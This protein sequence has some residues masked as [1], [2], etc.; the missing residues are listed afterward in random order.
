MLDSNHPVLKKGLTDAG[1]EVEEDFR[2]PP[3][4]V[5][6]S[7]SEYQGIVVRSRFPISREFL[8]HGSLNFIGRVGAGLENIDLKACNELGIEVFNA[9]EGNRDA[10]GE[11]AIGMLLSLFNNL[12]K[13]DI[14]VRTGVWKREENRGYEIQGKTIGIIGYGNMGSAFAKKLSGFDA[15]VIAYD[16]YKQGFCSKVVE[17]VSLSRL[18]EESD[19]ISLHIP[20]TEETV[21]MVN[22]NFID[23]C[24]RPFYLINTA[25]GSAVKTTSLVDGIKKGKIKGA[26][27]DVLEY[28]KSSFENLFSGQLPEAFDYLTKSENVVLS[29][30]IAGW[31]HESNQK[32]AQVIVDKIVKWKSDKNGR[33]QN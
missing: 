30:H 16:K 21:H 19:V 20:Q 9:P 2:S 33:E 18:Q 22:E 13:A 3:G 32:L 5:A 6:K 1:F 25:R 17:E 10:V 23:A 28:E 8:S 4:E 29:P 31:T 24:A 12:K 26:C 11:Q 27:L 14:E 7:L 15:R